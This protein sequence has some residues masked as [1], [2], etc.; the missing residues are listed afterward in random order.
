MFFH[1]F[2]EIQCITNTEKYTLAGRTSPLSHY[3][4]VPPSP[5]PLGTNNRKGPKYDSC[6]EPLRKTAVNMKKV[7][8]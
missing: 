2:K 6:L 7:V 5:P 8:I 4:G 1:N 3:E